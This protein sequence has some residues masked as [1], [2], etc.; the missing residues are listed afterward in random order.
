MRNPH[1]ALPVHE[2]KSLEQIS[3]NQKARQISKATFRITQ[4]VDLPCPTRPQPFSA[5]APAAVPDRTMSELTRPFHPDVPGLASTRRRRRPCPRST[6]SR[7][8]CRRP[9][10]W[11]RRKTATAAAAAAWRRAA[12]PTAF[13]TLPSTA[14]SRTDQFL[15][16]QEEFFR[17]DSPK[18]KEIKIDK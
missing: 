3:F 15:F 11:P 9:T 10:R 18:T 6:M 1:H 2:R 13:S 16:R 12:A 4:L 7:G 14:F 5:A 8:P 17:G